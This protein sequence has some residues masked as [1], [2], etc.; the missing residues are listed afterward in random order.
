MVQS[1]LSFP[2]GSV[3]SLM[4]FDA[5]AIRADVALDVGA[6]LAAPARLAA[7][8][9]AT[10]PVVDATACCRRAAPRPPAHPAG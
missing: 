9:V 7:D 3:G 4:E 10:L 2:E 5:T 1:A 6:A 8:S